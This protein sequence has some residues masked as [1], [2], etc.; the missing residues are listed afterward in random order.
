MSKRIKESKT[1]SSMIRWFCSIFLAAL[2]ENLPLR[3]ESLS[4]RMR[5]GVAKTVAVSQLSKVKLFVYIDIIEER[6][7]CV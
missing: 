1:P 5:A 6:R 3:F 7:A 2:N 4:D